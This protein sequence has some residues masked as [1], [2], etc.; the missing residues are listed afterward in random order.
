MVSGSEG[1]KW[2]VVVDTLR[3][4]D[5]I[6]LGVELLILHGS[7]LRSETPRDIDLVAIVSDN[8]DE[9]DVAL[10]IME[11][12]ESR[13]GLEA[14]VYIV[15]DPGDANCF[16]LWE[17]LRNGVIVYQKSVGR[18]KLVKAINICYDFMLSREKLGYTETL[19]KR[20][21]RDAT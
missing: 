13:F 3:S 12:V 15:K 18:E 7:V 10:R 8:V 19:V 11:F 5:W 21:M 4:V 1:R 20:V 16:L 6:G 9:D 14:D 17:A 2:L